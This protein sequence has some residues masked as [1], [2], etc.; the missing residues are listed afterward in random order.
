VEIR[1]ADEIANTGQID[2]LLKEKLE[3]TFH[4]KWRSG[5]LRKIVSN[6]LY[7]PCFKAKIS[8]MMDPERGGYRGDPW[9]R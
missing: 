4:L 5:S 3:K 6:T 8:S 7:F 9:G 2:D 1:G